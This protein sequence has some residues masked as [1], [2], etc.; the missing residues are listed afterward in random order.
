MAV[1]LVPLAAV[2]VED[3]Y[4]RDR[5]GDVLA[6]GAHVLHGGRTD[7]AGDAGEALDARPAFRDRPLDQRIP[8]LAG[9][10]RQLDRVL[11]RHHLDAADLQVDDE[12][13]EALVRDDEV[14]APAEEEQ[15]PAFSA[16]TTSV[17]EV[18]VV[19]TVAAV[20]EGAEELG[21]LAPPL[22]HA[23]AVSAAPTATTLSSRPPMT[24]AL[25]S[26][27]IV[28]VPAPDS[29]KSYSTRWMPAFW[30]WI[31]AP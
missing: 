9:A 31:P 29:T 24:T 11:R 10:R 23:A 19:T 18:V 8:R 28:F 5:L 13:G 15:R 27:L 12:A 3:A 17:V 2:E 16:L 30:R 22:E 21:E 7:E 6:V 1:E 20:V 4:A 26:T 14:A 25:P